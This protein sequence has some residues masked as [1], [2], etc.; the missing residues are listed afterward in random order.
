MGKYNTE[1]IYDVNEANEI[2]QSAFVIDQFY[3]GYFNIE[4]HPLSGSSLNLK[5]IPDYYDE[6]LESWLSEH[7][8]GK[9]KVQSQTWRTPVTNH[10]IPSFFHI[11]DENEAESFSMDLDD[12]VL[13]NWP[14]INIR[15][16]PEKY[17]SVWFN[18]EPDPTPND[19]ISLHDGYIYNFDLT[20]H[21]GLNDDINDEYGN[22]GDSY[23]CH[24]SMIAI[25]YLYFNRVIRI[26]DYA[27]DDDTFN[28]IEKS[29]EFMSFIKRL[30]PNEELSKISSARKE[31]KAVISA[32]FHKFGSKS[33]EKLHEI[34][35]WITQN[36]STYSF[37]FGNSV[38][39]I[40]YADDE[41]D[42]NDTEFYS[43]PDVDKILG[44]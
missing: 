2:Y 41:M 31:H 17:L 43:R 6:M 7:Y 34:K 13:E 16:V 20:E 4:D 42:E 5:S 10:L 26:S 39:M 32:M 36:K 12:W 3:N 25:T 8:A 11:I 18:D 29:N 9:N 38:I 1:T 30:M 19:I 14:K 35:Q 21:L 33:A 28:Q 37:P 15:Y 44:E 22:F 27:I 40:T 23:E 24:D